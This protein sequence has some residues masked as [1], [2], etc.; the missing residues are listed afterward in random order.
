MSVETFERAPAP[1]WWRAHWLENCEEF[2][3]EGAGETIG[4][5]E[6]I[7]ENE[8]GEAAALLVESDTRHIRIAVAEIDEIDPFRYLVT[9]KR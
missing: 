8:D 3:V 2:R 5:V 4:F 1:P 7:E 6:A 9:L